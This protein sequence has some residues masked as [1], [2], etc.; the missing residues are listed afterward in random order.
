[1]Q[2]ALGPPNNIQLQVPQH[3]QLDGKKRYA[4]PSGNAFRTVGSFSSFNDQTPNG[5]PSQMN[6]VR[7]GMQARIDPILAIR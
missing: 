7:N 1:M 2:S 3:S 5:I 6:G 4:S